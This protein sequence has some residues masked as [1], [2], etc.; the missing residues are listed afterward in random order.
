[1]RDDLLLRRPSHLIGLARDNALRPGTFTAR[2]ATRDP[3]RYQTFEHD[4]RTYT[5][6]HR[7]LVSHRLA[8][9]P[10]QY[11][12]AMPEEIEDQLLRKM[13]PKNDDGMSITVRH[14]AKKGSRE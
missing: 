5:L 12:Q 14:D 4:G 6:D 8:D 1:M 2:R 11:R 7:R 9:V 10:I 13:D 3:N